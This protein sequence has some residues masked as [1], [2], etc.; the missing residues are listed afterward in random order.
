MKE[1]ELYSFVEFVDK[2]RRM[3]TSPFFWHLFFPLASLLILA[4]SSATAMQ[5][6][7]YLPIVSTAAAP[8]PEGCNTCAY[9]A[10]NCSDFPSQRA[11]QACFQFCLDEVGVDIHRL[12]GDNDGMACELLPLPDTH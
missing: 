10:Y 12:D 2:T 1:L 9:D 4:S 8:V 3:M 6:A 5:T 11:A 7:V